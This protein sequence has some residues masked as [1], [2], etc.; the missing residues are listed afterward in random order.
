MST[1]VPDGSVPVNGSVLAGGL[2]AATTNAKHPTKKRMLETLTGTMDI[3]A[4]IQVKR[5]IRAG[6]L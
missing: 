3:D 5:H 6:R 1:A 2:H 4:A